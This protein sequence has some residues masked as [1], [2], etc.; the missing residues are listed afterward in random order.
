MKEIMFTVGIDSVEIE[1]FRPW[2]N[3]SHKTLRKIYSETELA[4]SFSNESKKLERLA[5]RFAAKEAFFK[6]IIQH[7][8]LPVSILRICS[9][10]SIE[11]SPTGIPLLDID[12]DR[13]GLPN[14][15]T[16]QASFTHTQTTAIAVVVVIPGLSFD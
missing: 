3:F 12:W 15:F 4:Y 10:C 5:V 8:T 16:T 11:V 7:I 1:R 13:I 2:I 6:A 9:V 14:T